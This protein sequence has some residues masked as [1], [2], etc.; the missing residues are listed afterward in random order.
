MSVHLEKEIRR[1]KSR[2]LELS[3]IV[4]ESVYLAVKAAQERDA[5]S[6]EKISASDRRVDIMEVEIEEECLKALALYQPMAIDLRVVVAILKINSDLERI[7]DLAV[8]IAHRARS[9]AALD[10][11]ENISLDYE[12]MED[13]VRKMLRDSLQSLINL[14]GELAHKVLVADEE[15]DEINRK[16]Y[17]KATEMLKANPDKSGTLLMRINVARNLERIADHA[18]N[19]AEDVIYMIEG[20][21]VRHG[22]RI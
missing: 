16:V 22:L 20:S 14:D 15:V 17:L 6:A 2:I 3:A 7:G 5:E 13:K 9:L 1:L 10:P 21:I 19:I 8:N 11:K 4:E 12:G 18:T